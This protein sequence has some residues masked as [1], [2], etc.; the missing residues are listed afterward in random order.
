M[1]NGDQWPTACPSRL[2]K[3]TVKINGVFHC[4]LCFKTFFSNF[5]SADYIDSQEPLSKKKVS[6]YM[7]NLKMFK[8]PEDVEIG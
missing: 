6:T 8:N 7:E 4:V 1:G 3:A 2:Q 5:E